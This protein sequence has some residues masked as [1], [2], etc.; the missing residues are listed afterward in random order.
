MRKEDVK[1]GDIVY[2]KFECEKYT[3]TLQVLECLYSDMFKLKVLE[4]RKYS[5]STMNLYAT[6]FWH[7][8]S[9]AKYISDSSKM[10]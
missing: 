2:F 10:E 4:P 5:N 6:E 8:K 3:R 7:D 1:I 9:Y